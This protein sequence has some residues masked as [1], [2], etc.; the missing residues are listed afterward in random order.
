MLLDAAKEIERVLK[1]RHVDAR[2]RDG[3]R[4]II[5][6]LCFYSAL[7]DEKVGYSVNSNIVPFHKDGDLK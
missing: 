7:L 6:M 4:N 1:N 5:N 2:T 3:L